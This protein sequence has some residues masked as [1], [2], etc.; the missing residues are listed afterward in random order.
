MYL[1]QKAYGEIPVIRNVTVRK[2]DRII[3]LEGDVRLENDIDK[4]RIRKGRAVPEP[5]V[6]VPPVELEGVPAEQHLYD[7]DLLGIERDGNFRP[8]IPLFADYGHRVFYKRR[9]LSNRVDS[10]FYRVPARI[11]THIIRRQ[12]FIRPQPCEPGRI[13]K[14]KNLVELLLKTGTVFNAVVFPSGLP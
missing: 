9:D 10:R 7:A 3:A 6:D 1:K 2:R 14:G 12:F 4:I 5:A 11:L 8:E 13:E